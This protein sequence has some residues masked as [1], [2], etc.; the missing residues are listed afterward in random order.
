MVPGCDSRGDGFVALR[1][2]LHHRRHLPR[3][4]NL[5]KMLLCWSMHNRVLTERKLFVRHSL[6]QASLLRF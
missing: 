6:S 5:I 3:M 4:I 2:S 1:S